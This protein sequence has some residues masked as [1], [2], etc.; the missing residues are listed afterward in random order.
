MN[1][2]QEG[3]KVFFNTDNSPEM[4]VDAVFHPEQ[5]K[6]IATCYWF[7]NSGELQTASFHTYLLVKI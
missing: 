2:F 4:V 6:E 1:I 5:G 3:D 7:N